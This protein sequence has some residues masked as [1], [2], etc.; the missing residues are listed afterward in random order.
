MCAYS[1]GVPN[2]R[3]TF[4]SRAHPSTSPY[5]NLSAHFKHLVKEG[6]LQR[7]LLKNILYPEAR[8]VNT[9]HIRLRRKHNTHSGRRRRS[10]GSSSDL[11][12]PGSNDFP[13]GESDAISSAASSVD[14]QRY[15][16]CKI[17][18]DAQTAS[19]DPS[20][21]TFVDHG[22]RFEPDCTK[23]IFAN[24]E[25]GRRSTDVALDRDSDGSFIFMH[26]RKNSKKCDTDSKD[27]L[28][29]YS[30]PVRVVI[31]RGPGNQTDS[32][33]HT[34]T[35]ELLI[36]ANSAASNSKALKTEPLKPGRKV[37][38]LSGL[39]KREQNANMACED[40]ANMD[41]TLHMK[42]SAVKK[43]TLCEE[44]HSMPTQFV[45][46]RFNCSS[47]TEV[48]I[49]SYKERKE[50][51]NIEQ[52]LDQS[53]SDMLE[54]ESETDE[55]GAEARA[56]LLSTGTHSSTM[57]IPA[58]IPAPSL[59]TAELL[60]N[61]D[62]PVAGPS[63][64]ARTTLASDSHVIK[65]P[66][67]F[68]GNGR[69]SLNKESSPFNS[70]ALNSDKKIVMRRG[71]GDQ[72]KSKN[73]RCISYHYINL[74]GEDMPSKLDDLDDTSLK[75]KKCECCASSRCPSPRSSDSGMAGSCTISS[76]D[77]PTKMFEQDY[78]PFDTEFADE[79]EPTMNPLM[80]SQSSHNFGRFNDI[81]FRDNNHDSGQYGHS[82]MAPEDAAGDSLKEADVN[83]MF[84]LSVSRDTIKRQSRCQSAERTLDHGTNGPNPNR[85]LVFKTGLYAHWWKKVDIN[86]LVQQRSTPTNRGN[87]KPNRIGWDISHAGRS[88]D[89]G[90]PSPRV[91]WGS[92]K[93]FL[94]EFC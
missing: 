42:E 93:T 19:R 85:R 81:T 75:A 26:N 73:K 71:S 57:D 51:P 43:I 33:V 66:S 28:K 61:L 18:D 52:M 48:Y 13:E 72:E 53:Q 67:M 65:P 31:D 2:Y 34:S 27:S 20:Q 22:S 44:R 37:S 69:I 6:L 89:G 47:L 49:P 77:A 30:K 17:S 74:Q 23:D 70:H 32:I 62:Q 12:H 24:L 84:E 76:P 87:S 16:K 38:D 60:Y 50:T 55:Y 46:N 9:S 36:G 82:S 58:L 88:P 83:N 7:L 14:F 8:S 45:G 68:D 4:P 56:S 15:Y 11:S 92:G 86:N 39:L 59:M 78:G 40:L 41:D 54:D 35:A 1:L 94:S 21:D 29:Y 10:I 80:H 3:L 79:P 64:S 91:G 90:E 5:S 25:T 63:S